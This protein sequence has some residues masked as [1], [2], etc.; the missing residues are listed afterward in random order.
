MIKK[1]GL[2]I[3]NPIIA[4]KKS[5]MFLNKFTYIKISKFEI[6]SLTRIE[7]LYLKI[8]INWDIF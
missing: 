3:I 1:K 8:Q 7:I 6:S 4:I 2:K 5:I